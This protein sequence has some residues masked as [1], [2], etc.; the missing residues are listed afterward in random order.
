MCYSAALMTT[1]PAP[2]KNGRFTKVT[3]QNQEETDDDA[4]VGDEREYDQ[5]LGLD[6]EGD[7]DA[8][9]DADEDDVD[10]DDVDE[11]DADDAESEPEPEPEVRY[12]PPPMVEPRMDRPMYDTT[13]RV[14]SYNLQIRIEQ[15]G[16]ALKDKRRGWIAIKGEKVPL[17]VARWF[18][19]SD[20]CR[21]DPATGKR[22]YVWLDDKMVRDSSGEPIVDEGE[23]EDGAIALR[24]P[25]SAPPMPVLTDAG[26]Q[27]TAL[28]HQRLEA[29]TNGATRELELAREHYHREMGRLQR[30]LEIEEERV[31]K[32]IEESK[33]RMI[34]QLAREEEQ[35]E[36]ADARR[37]KASEARE[38]LAASIKRDADTYEG[39]RVT[40]QEALKPP[41]TT[42]ASQTE[43]IVAGI[44]QVTEI[45]AVNEVI[46]GLALFLMKKMGAPVPTP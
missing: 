18:S 2:R 22:V 19:S 44:K 43:T 27:T 30:K 34:L 21:P 31:Q 45:P 40:L 10:E 23:E 35:E 4:R 39:V 14:A 38:A 29:L 1:T 25:S 42:P 9:D 3:A 26:L 5:G 24:P 41:T 46:S 37:E 12:Q 32:A 6:L 33:A 17:E 15:P 11:D 13:A 8:D 28:I 7:D 20:C 16:P 36:Q